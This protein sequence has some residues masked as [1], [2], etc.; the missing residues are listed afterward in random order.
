[1]ARA[2]RAAAAAPA[3]PQAPAPAPHLRLH[4][5]LLRPAPE[6][7][8]AASSVPADL[9]DTAFTEAVAAEVDPGAD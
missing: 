9:F 7:P 8:V 5:H 3:E 2:P 6:P 1:M 4:L